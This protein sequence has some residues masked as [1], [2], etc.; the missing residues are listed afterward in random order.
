M[1]DLTDEQF[2]TILNILACIDGSQIRYSITGLM[3][4]IKEFQKQTK[5]DVMTC[6][7]EYDDDF[8]EYLQSS[9]T[10]FADSIGI[11]M[12][13]ERKPIVAL[14]SSLDIE[15]INEKNLTSSIASFNAECK[16]RGYSFQIPKKT[17][18]ET[19]K[20]VFVKSRRFETAIA[21]VKLFQT[22]LAVGE[23][24]AFT[25]KYAKMPSSEIAILVKQIEQAEQNIMANILD[26]DIALSESKK[27][28]QRLG[29]LPV[30]LENKPPFV[31]IQQIGFEMLAA[32]AILYG[33]KYFKTE[34]LAE[35]QIRDSISLYLIYLGQKG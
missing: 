31:L 19:L 29:R 30:S 9:K 2:N 35:D 22:R 18:L 17:S 27:V 24:Y 14:I 7:K 21:N 15:K 28:L 16:R 4:N 13:K 25:S 12:P 32:E 11:T 33:K 23:I 10:Y 5:F 8:L 20:S 6:L 26:Y 3:A 1:D 34:T